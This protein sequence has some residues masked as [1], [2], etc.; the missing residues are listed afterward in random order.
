MNM[1]NQRFLITVTHNLSSAGCQNLKKLL[2]FA[3]GGLL[4]DVFLHLLPEAWAHPSSNCKKKILFFFY[5][6][7]GSGHFYSSSCFVFLVIL[8]MSCFFSTQTWF[9]INLFIHLLFYLSFTWMS[10]VVPYYKRFIHKGAVFKSMQE[11]YCGLTGVL[12][13][14]QLFIGSKVGR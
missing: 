14:R 3:I 2:S 12:S 8:L 5:L 1:L 11:W 13:A 9:K 6:K 4:G 10:F 7:K